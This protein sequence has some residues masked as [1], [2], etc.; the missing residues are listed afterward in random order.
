MAYFST[1]YHGQ[2]SRKQ[3]KCNAE[4]STAAAA[5]LR[6]QYFNEARKRHF[7]FDLFEQECRNSQSKKNQKVSDSLVLYIY[8]PLNLSNLDF[9]F[10]GLFW[11]L[12][13]ARRNLLAFDF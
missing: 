2:G 4:F 1:F 8:T 7:Q 6:R 11:S 5:G 9:S 12:K 3:V 13:I 10:A